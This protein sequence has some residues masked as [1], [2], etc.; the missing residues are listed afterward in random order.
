MRDLRTIRIFLSLLFM[1]AAVAALFVGNGVNPLA[2]GAEKVQI[3]PSALAMTMGA[4]GFWL[5][6]TFMFGRI[7]CSTVCPVGTL[8]DS[9]TW[10]RRRILR[11]SAATPPAPGR[12]RLIRPF[13]YRREGK[14]RFPVLLA[15]AV[16]LLLGMTGV[17]ATIEPWNM[18]RA[19]ARATNPE[20]ASPALLF[21]AHVAIGVAFAVAV[22]LAVWL[23]A[24]WGGRR[25]CS[26]V[27]PI[28]TVLGCVSRF[29]LY[30]IEI[31]PE[32]CTNCMR[33]EEACKT[34][35]IK[36]AGRYVDNERCVRCF[37]CL[38][39]CADD[40]INLQRTRN[41]RINPLMK[42]RLDGTEP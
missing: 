4:T 35:S 5:V 39:V 25:F 15:Y 9:A 22:L 36:V 3:I 18:M 32:R 34:Q 11:R 14:L 38:K 28:G 23:A 17:A 24:L 6:A 30:H 7:Y 41:R 21:S 40:A 26:E 31:D 27:C 33:C 2:S 19:A 16:C 42:K 10:L 13:R 29:S 12:R 37:D 20:A 8:Q 1:A